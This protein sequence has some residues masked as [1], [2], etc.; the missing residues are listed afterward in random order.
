[1]QSQ[2]VDI[3]EEEEQTKAS[4]TT[5]PVTKGTAL[6]LVELDYTKS[7]G[8]FR[9][10]K[11]E[12]G[13]LI[14]GST[15]EITTE[16]TLPGAGKRTYYKSWFSKDLHIPLLATIK[17][18]GAVIQG[19]WANS[20]ERPKDSSLDPAD[21]IN[22]FTTDLRHEVLPPPGGWRIEEKTYTPPSKA[23][24]TY[25]DY[26]NTWSYS[27]RRDG[28]TRGH[29]I[30]SNIFR[31]FFKT[32]AER[33]NPNPVFDAATYMT[34][35][36]PQYRYEKTHLTPQEQKEHGKYFPAFWNFAEQM[37]EEAAKHCLNFVDPTVN[38]LVA[39]KSNFFIAHGTVPGS[40]TMGTTSINIPQKMFMAYCCSGRFR[41]TKASVKN[42]KTGNNYEITVPDRYLQIF[43]QSPL[44]SRGVGIEPDE[45]M[46]T[47][48]DSKHRDSITKFI[49][50]LEYDSIANDKNDVLK[51]LKSFMDQAGC[52]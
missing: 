21:R 30:A 3:E 44:T 37:E 1:M 39:K 10:R 38:L 22:S 35:V 36:F 2:V 26:T 9:K 6:D 8:P 48:E 7:K 50:Q 45:E 43:K 5:L 23:V 25:A 46:F 33:D 15:G 42:Y 12:D 51:E 19:W 17:L 14:F 13:S 41:S 31:S 40:D 27:G 16:E 47:P 29:L 32:E 34:N 4:R 11:E 20:L 18:E 28:I 49:D 52:F 24:G